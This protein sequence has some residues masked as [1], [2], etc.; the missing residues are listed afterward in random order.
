ML[1]KSVLSK[2]IVAGEPQAYKGISDDAA[3]LINALLDR[4]LE[5]VYPL[6]SS[7]VPIQVMSRIN[8]LFPG[9]NAGWVTGALEIDL[10]ENISLPIETVK[11]MVKAVAGD[12]LFTRDG[13]KYATILVE[14]FISSLMG[15]IAD[16]LMIT[17]P[18]IVE[19]KHIVDYLYT[20]KGLEDIE[21]HQK[22]LGPLNKVSVKSSTKRRSGKKSARR[23]SSKRSSSKRSSSKRKSSRRCSPGKIRVKSFIRD[24]QRIKSYCRKK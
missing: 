20:H 10:S 5:V 24:G 12:V 7:T 22:P 21:F 9:S 16:A 11:K 6:N 13:E 23:S 18:V 4:I 15:A 8:K 1:S 2:F 3:K 19:G 17:S 14:V